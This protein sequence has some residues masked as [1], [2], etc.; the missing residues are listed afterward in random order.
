MRL[1][2]IP[3]PVIVQIVEAKTLAQLS[4]QTERVLEELARVQ[5]LESL[6]ATTEFFGPEFLGKCLAFG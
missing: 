4:S 3:G 5:V 6:P 1:W 2:P